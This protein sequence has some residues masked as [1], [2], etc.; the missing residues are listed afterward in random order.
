M[1]MKA[2]SKISLAL[3]AILFL[4]SFGMRSEAVAQCP[5]YYNHVIDTVTISG[6]C[7][8]EVDLCVLCAFSYPGEIKIN[9]VTALDSSCSNQDPEIILKDIF[10]QL[11]NYPSFWFDYCGAFP[12]CGMGTERIKIYKPYCWKLKR[13]NTVEDRYEFLRCS[14]D[15]CIEIYDFC[16][17]SNGQTH[18]VLVSSSSTIPPGVEI[19]CHIE[20]EDLVLPKNAYEESECFILHTLC[21]P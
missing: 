7:S 16:T 15:A 2:I 6:G 13:L 18:K 8:Y 17:D 21:N 5:P 20:G 9:K 10:T 11:G 1:I 3:V 4:L 14:D 12:P 19:P